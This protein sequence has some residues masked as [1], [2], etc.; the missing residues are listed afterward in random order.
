[1]YAAELR[2]TFSL[3]RPAGNPKRT[4]KRRRRRRK[5]PGPPVPSPSARSVVPGEA[6]PPASQRAPARGDGLHHEQEKLAPAVEPHLAVAG[7]KGIA[8]KNHDGSPVAAGEAL[9]APEQVDLFARVQLL[10]EAARFA[11]RRRLAEDERPR[12]PFVDAAHGV[13]DSGQ[14]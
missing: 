12:R 9:Q 5:S 4:G 1:A 13:P 10:A 8:V 14:E 3:Q 7:V 2:A 6:F 11:E